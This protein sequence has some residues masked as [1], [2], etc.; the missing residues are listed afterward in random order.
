MH[1]GLAEIILERHLEDLLASLIQLG[2][3]PLQKPNDDQSLKVDANQ[4][5][6]TYIM[7]EDRY[8]TLL[9]N[10]ANFQTHLKNVLEKVYPPVAIKSLLLLQS[11]GAT[12]VIR[13]CDLPPNDETVPFFKVT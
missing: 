11:S 13:D 8:E 1:D 6:S 7:T 4:C 10:Q 9:A 2:H 3:R 12:E 5:M